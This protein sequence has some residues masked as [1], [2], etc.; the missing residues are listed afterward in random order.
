[1]AR[2]KSEYIKQAETFKND[3]PTNIST[4]E[5]TKKEICK[6]L[7]YNKKTQELDIDFKGYGIRLFHIKRNDNSKENYVTI[8]FN[9]EIGKSNFKCRYPNV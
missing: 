6:V 1:M 5:F 4:N 8:L 3:S 2:R 9:G 7:S